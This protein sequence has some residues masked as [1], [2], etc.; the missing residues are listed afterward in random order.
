M[1]M[2]KVKPS[3]ERSTLTCRVR[4]VLEELWKHLVVLTS[5]TAEPNSDWLNPHSHPRRER[6]DQS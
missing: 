1:M 4:G 3:D 5:C 6:E 2:N